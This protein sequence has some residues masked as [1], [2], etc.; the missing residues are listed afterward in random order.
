MLHLSAFSDE[1][2]PAI[3]PQVEH[4]RKNG[5]THIELRMVDKINV[6]DFTAD[7]RK[8]IK[9][10]LDAGGRVGR[11][12]GHPRA[13]GLGAVGPD[14]AVEVPQPG[15]VVRIV[16]PAG[17]VGGAHARTISRPPRRL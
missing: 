17:A 7:Q 14:D 11:H 8:A 16:V 15:V 4:C 3:G 6:L 1:I 9:S 2:D 12:P 13:L 5:V 10:A